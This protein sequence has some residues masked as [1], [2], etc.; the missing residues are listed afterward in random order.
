DFIY[1]AVTVDI[2]VFKRVFVRERKI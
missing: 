1:I 2:T